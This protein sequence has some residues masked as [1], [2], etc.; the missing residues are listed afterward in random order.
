VLWVQK[1]KRW[2]GS[3]PPKRKRPGCFLTQPS[4]RG[5]APEPGKVLTHASHHRPVRSTFGPSYSTGTLYLSRFKFVI[6]DDA[7][8]CPAQSSPT[9]RCQTVYQERPVSLRT[10][11]KWWDNGVAQSFHTRPRVVLG[12]DSIGDQ[13]WVIAIRRCT[14]IYHTRL[15][16]QPLIISFNVRLDPEAQKCVAP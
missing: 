10:T 3:D 13:G 9:P 16:T 15:G 14:A 6:L 5:D 11:V 2:A 4:L 8:S 1:S 7:D 12:E